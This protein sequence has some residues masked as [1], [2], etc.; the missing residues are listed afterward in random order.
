M[1]AQSARRGASCC[2]ASW[3]AIS[4]A[5][6]RSLAAVTATDSPERRVS[7]LSA[8]AAAAIQN[9]S[10]VEVTV[11]VPQASGMVAHLELM[12]VRGGDGTLRA[13]E[14]YC[15]HAGGPL[16]MVPD[17]FFDRSGKHLMC[18]RHGA[19]F[20]PEGGECVHGP[21]PGK[22]LHPLPVEADGD[23]GVTTS[24]AALQSVC[25][26]GGGAYVLRGEGGGGGGAAAA[27]RADGSR[28]TA[29]RRA[30]MPTPSTRRRE[31]VAPRAPAEMDATAAREVDAAPGRRDSVSAE[32]AA[33]APARPPPC[34]WQPGRDPFEGL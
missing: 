3:N 13:F 28:Q 19:L 16:N 9:R 31:R 12:L 18:T 27:R 17:R 6:R 22:R 24:L 15:P 33:G 7:L 20:S 21:C 14:N 34:P 26:H 8:A 30:S 23:Y 4:C 29:E 2:A 11:P 10:A 5:S 1:F 25:D 32:R